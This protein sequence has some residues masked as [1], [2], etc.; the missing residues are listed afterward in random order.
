MSRVRLFDD[1]LDAELVE[2]INDH[3]RIQTALDAY[4]LP[5]P[6]MEAIEERFTQ[7]EDDK[8]KLHKAYF[9]PP[10]GQPRLSEE[11]YYEQLR[12]ISAEQE[13]L[14]HKRLVN[15]E[16]EPLRA[17]LR[18]DTPWTVEEWRREPLGWRRG[19]IQLVTERIE[20]AKSPTR[21]GSL[22][23]TTGGYFDRERIR[24]KFIG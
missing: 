9:R 17:L 5:T 21:G 22:K 20:V 14:S 19:I 8:I 18:R 7:L 12:E 4:R 1:V 3:G 13:E 11:F 6:D 24:I 15:R 10:K 23:G 2:F 16:A